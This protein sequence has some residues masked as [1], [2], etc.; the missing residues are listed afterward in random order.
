[1]KHLKKSGHRCFAANFLN[2]MGE[3][4]VNDSWSKLVPFSPKKL[5]EAFGRQKSRDII[6]ICHPAKYDKICK[7]ISLKKVLGYCG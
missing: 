7:P 4:N 5:L 3:F 2:Y 1:M 6:C